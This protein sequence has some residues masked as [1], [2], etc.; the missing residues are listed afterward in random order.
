MALFVFAPTTRLHIPWVHS[1][2]LCLLIPQERRCSLRLAAKPKP[3]A[4]E[5]KKKAPAK[6]ATKAKKA[7][8][9]ENGS[10]KAEEPK[11]EAAE[12]KW[13]MVNVLNSVYLVIVQF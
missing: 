4:V 12:A 6:K 3:A 2:S 8:P 9:A 5:T 10:S 11:A 7:K 13:I 1:V